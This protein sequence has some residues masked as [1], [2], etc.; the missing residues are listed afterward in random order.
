MTEDHPTKRYSFG[1][2][3]VAVVTIIEGKSFKAY[4]VEGDKVDVDAAG[5]G[6]TV[7]EAIADL[8][9]ALRKAEAE[10]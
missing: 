7:L 2:D 6:S 3:V 5:Y 8:T 1:D 10:Q 4:L 9:A